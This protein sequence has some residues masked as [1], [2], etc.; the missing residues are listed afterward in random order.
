MQ[1][2]ILRVALRVPLQLGT[3][4]R[5]AFVR[6]CSS[7][8]SLQE[9]SAGRLLLLLQQ[10]K[11]P[12]SA[13]HDVGYSR[14]PTAVRSPCPAAISLPARPFAAPSPLPSSADTAPARE[15]LGRSFGQPSTCALELQHGAPPACRAAETGRETERAFHVQQ[16]RTSNHQSLSFLLSSLPAMKCSLWPHASNSRASQNS[17]CDEQKPPLTSSN[18]SFIAA[19]ASRSTVATAS[20]FAS[21]AADLASCNWCSS[22]RQKRRA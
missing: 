15:G 3:Q 17:H 7:G 12:E 11:V 13:L 14:G 1:A 6:H 20:C 9:R 2:W 4:S 18:S 10:V 22:A 21:S 16:S 5:T 8:I 19:S